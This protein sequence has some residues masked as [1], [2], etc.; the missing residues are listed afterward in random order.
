MSAGSAVD[1]GM[2]SKVPLF[3]GLTSGQ[4]EK[5]ASSLRPMSFPAH[6]DI[7]M[8]EQ[9]GEAVYIILSGTLKVHVEQADGRDVILALLGPGQTVGE[10]S[11]VD[12]VG[13]SASVLTLEDTKLL[14]M[15]RASF[16]ACVTTIPRLSLNLMRVF[17]R[18]LRLANI[19]IASL[20]TLDVYGRV[21]RQI[22]AL[23][24][25]YG[26]EAPE[27][28]VYVP[29]S[30]TQSDL[31]D[32]VGASRVRVNQVLIDYRQRGYISV[33]Q[34]HHVTVH[35]KTALEHRAQ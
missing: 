10:M 34:A 2:L 26:K 6:R 32:I 8:T 1:P 28:G 33:D 30:L 11:I 15:D 21:A 18:R 24:D 25:E 3:E 31:A 23:A 35:D 12:E 19:Q 20:A 5:V 17:S 22:L 7:M 14:W 29:L 9:P 4:L 27:G 13:R 16:L